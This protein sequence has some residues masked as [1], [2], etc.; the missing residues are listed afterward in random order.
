MTNRKE[1]SFPWWA[2]PFQSSFW[3]WSALSTLAHLSVWA[4]SRSTPKQS[5][6]LG[7]LSRPTRAELM[8][9]LCCWWTQSTPAGAVFTPCSVTVL[10][11]SKLPH[12]TMNT[13]RTQT[14]LYFS[15]YL[16][17]HSRS[18]INIWWIND[19]ALHYLLATWCW[20]SYIV[21]LYLNF[22]ICGL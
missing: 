11:L 17:A 4:L 12:D 2:I 1:H 20:V 6:F 5:G 18:L 16:M 7:N 13:L 15:S 3:A 14:A 10:R 19:S 9:L 8:M 22:P 21:S